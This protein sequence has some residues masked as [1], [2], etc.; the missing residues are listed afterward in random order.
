[1]SKSCRSRMAFKPANDEDLKIYIHLD[2][3]SKLAKAELKDLQEKIKKERAVERLRFEVEKRAEWES[4]WPDTPYPFE[5]A[6]EEASSR[7][8]AFVDESGSKEKVVAPWRV[9]KQQ[10]EMQQLQ[11]ADDNVTASKRRRE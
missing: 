5:S 11:S 10:R 2:L 3:Q 9:K 8:N 1:M 4:L 7:V 6:V